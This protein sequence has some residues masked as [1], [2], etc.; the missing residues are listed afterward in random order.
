MKKENLIL[1]GFMGTG[2]STV[3]KLLAQHLDYTFVDTDELIESRQGRSIASIFSADGEPVFRQLEAQISRELA[4]Q[5]GLVI[6]SGGRL[7][8]DK[9]NAAI[10]G[11]TGPVFCLT[12]EPEVIAARLAGDDGQRPLIDGPQ[13]E[14]RISALLEER[15][16]AYGRFPQISTSQRTPQQIAQEIQFLLGQEILPVAYPHGQYNVIVGSDLLPRIRQ[17][18][19][20]EGPLAVITDSNVG[21][22]HANGVDTSDFVVTIPAGELFKTLA[23]VNNIYGELLAAGLDRQG[24][25][26]ALGGGV[27]GDVAGFVAA[28]YLRGVDFVQCPTSLLAMV[29][30]SVGAKTGVDLPQGKN[31]VGAFKQPLAVIADL[32]TLKTLPPQEFCAGMAEVIKAGLIADITLFSALEKEAALDS[33]THLSAALSL[34]TIVANSIAVKRNVVQ[35]DPF[36]KGRRA[37]LNLGHTFAHA[38][39][40][41]SGYA[42]RHGEAVAIGLVAAA[43]LSFSLGHCSETLQRR[44]ETVLEKTGLPRRIPDNLPP[45]A[46]YKAMGSDKKK[47]SGRLRFILIRDVGDVFISSDVPEEYVLQTLTACCQ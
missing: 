25:I 7:M 40:Q 33:P 15:S 21:P 17:L 34:S 28:T 32:D 37:V 11:A 6:A 30:A 19:G 31:L 4:Q 26:L 1:T 41:V 43:H 29:D 13:P 38:I 22:L 23:T 27:V 20:I 36:E 42:V 12:A 18:T 46:L 10:L 3:G 44:I 5:Q 47:V 39:E 8:L 9:E 14:A 2:K 45:A 24:T 35:E 16:A